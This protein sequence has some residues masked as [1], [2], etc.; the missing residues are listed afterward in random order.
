MSYGIGFALLSMSLS[1]IND[2]IFKHYS[3]GDRSR[4][5]LLFGVGLIWTLAQWMLTL[6]QD[7]PLE[8]NHPTLTFGLMAGVFL[9]LSNLLL[10]ESF[11]YLDVSLGTTIY[12]LNTI[13]VVLLSFL[14]LHETF[15]WIKGFGILLGLVGVFLLYKSKSPQSHQKQ[16]L[17]FVG[18]AGI[19][20][21]FRAAYGVSTK[22]GLLEDANRNAMLLV[23]ASSWIVGG[24]LYAIF[25]EKRFRLN[26]E[27]ARF[28]LISSILVVGIAN[29]LML[30]VQHGEA[31]T[32]IPVAN[33]SFVIAILLSTALKM[34]RL[35]AK[36]I[37][38]IICAAGSIF[39]LA[40]A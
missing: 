15:G 13:G 9:T 23:I 29:F 33:M 31:S 6:I 30:A 12:R 19:A 39:L 18:L 20:S 36:K 16:L 37:A 5:M 26:W 4:G 1:G 38:A 34:E 8:F 14:L 35:S 24:A 7:T 32:V 17:L 11:R 40:Q 3:V 27:K 21:L 2:V 28:I 10:L 22:A 25:R